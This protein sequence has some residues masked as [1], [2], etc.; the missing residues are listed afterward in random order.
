MRNRDRVL[1]IESKFK[2]FDDPVIPSQIKTI[3]EEVK[4]LFNC[5][6]NGIVAQLISSFEESVL[7]E[8][9]YGL[10]MY[11]LTKK[12]FLTTKDFELFNHLYSQRVSNQNRIKELYIN[13]SK[14]YPT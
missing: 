3:V 6:S 5:S 11:P 1:D 8:Y 13:L 2:E 10:R 7:E 12:A 4:R 14:H 9:Q